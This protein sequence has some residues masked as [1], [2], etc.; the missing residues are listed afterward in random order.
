MRIKSPRT[1]Q[2]MQPLF[3]SKISSSA[4]TTKVVINADFAKFVDDDGVASAV[5][6]AQNTIEQGGLARAEVAGQYRDGSVRR[7]RLP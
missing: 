2:Q 4:L 7:G 3:I 1:V 6:L 5:S